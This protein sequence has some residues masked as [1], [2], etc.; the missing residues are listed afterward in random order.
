MSKEDTIRH[1]KHMA[2]SEGLFVNPEGATTLAAC[3]K[4]R[5]KGWLKGDETVLCVM[6]SNGIKYDE[7]VREVPKLITE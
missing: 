6:T 7:L 4:L 1:W 3:E 5:K 2:Q